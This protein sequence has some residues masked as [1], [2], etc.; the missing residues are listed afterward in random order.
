MPR[1]KWIDCQQLTS[2]AQVL[3]GTKN[4]FMKKSYGRVEGPYQLL[5][6]AMD[7]PQFAWL[8]ALSAEMLP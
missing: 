8:R 5:G 1:D 2:T 6:L 7:D 4:A 3:L